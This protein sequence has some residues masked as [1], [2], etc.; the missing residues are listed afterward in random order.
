MQKFTW[1]NIKAYPSACASN[2]Y[3][4]KSSNWLPGGDARKYM[5][6]AKSGNNLEEA[7]DKTCQN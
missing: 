1:A 2:G 3:R 4:K 6:G 5:V 7:E